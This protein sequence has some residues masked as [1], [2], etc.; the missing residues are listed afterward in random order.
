M[1]K[2]LPLLLVLTLTM[3]SITALA[4]TGLGS[5]TSISGTNADGEKNGSATIN[6]YL[7]AL[8]LDED[9]KIIA[10]KFDVAQ[11]KVAYDEKGQWVEN[12]ADMVAGYPS[13]V[14][15]GENYGMV[16]AS[17]IGKEMFEQ[18]A[19]LEEYCLGKT[20]EEVL[21]VETYEKDPGHTQVPAG[22][23]LKSSV[24]ID[25]GGYLAVLKKAAEN[26]K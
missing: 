20:V 8:T 11:N 9:G 15:K 4:A 5:V 24:T 26:A 16:A 10:V 7:C 3:V 17:T 14:E 13:K 22:D 2:L 1:K 6:T 18:I 19:A 21:A 23:D 25:V 12:E